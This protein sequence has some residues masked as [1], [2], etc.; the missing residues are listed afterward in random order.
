MLVIDNWIGQLGNNILQIIRAIYFAKVHYKHNIISFPNHKY[1]T[2]NKIIIDENKSNP[3]V[4]KNNFFYLWKFGVK[5]PSPFEMKKIFQKYIKSIFVIKYIENTD[6]NKKLYIHIRSGDI[7][8]NNI[9]KSYVQPPLLFYK[10]CMS[11]YDNTII[12]FENKN[13][14]CINKLLEM[15]IDYQ[16]SNVVEDLQLLSSAKYLVIG[17]GTFGL[18]IYFLAEQIE[19]VYIPDYCLRELPDGDWGII[20]EVFTMDKYIKSGQWMNTPEQRKIMLEYTF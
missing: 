3:L 16:S 4:L 15:N 18:L 10:K 8:S 12:V 6:N 17:F 1:L 20:V 13:N 2:D 7:F 5:D 11:K 14:P 9:H 19:K